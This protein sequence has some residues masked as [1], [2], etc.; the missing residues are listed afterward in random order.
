MKKIAVI[1]ATGYVGSAVVAELARRGH[2]VT[3]FARNAD[4]VAKADNLQAVSFNVNS[5]DFARQLKGVN[6]VVS[7]FNPGCTNPNIAEDFTRGA[8]A[9]TEAA[10]AAQV[11]YLL[12]VGG[13]GSLYVAPN[14]QLIDTDAFPKEIFAGANAARNLLSDLRDRRDVNWAFI[15]PPALLGVTGG[16]SEDRTGEYRLGGDDL[17]M[18]SDA[19]AGISVADLAIAI[20]DD[21]EKQA[22]LFKRFTVASK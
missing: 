9:I 22:H 3:A 10:K 13:A 11:P 21:A 14:V 8:N 7:A 1:G 16:Y 15:S 5:A 4:K 12:I 6:A 18:D 17:L 20:A 19:P 2:Q